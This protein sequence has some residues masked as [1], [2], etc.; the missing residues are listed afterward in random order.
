MSSCMPL[1]GDEDIRVGVIMAQEYGVR[2]HLLGIK[3]A[4][5]NQSNLLLQEADVIHVW[6][7]PDVE[8]FILKSSPLHPASQFKRRI[9]SELLPWK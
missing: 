1:T 6:E 3:P 4:K 7:S 8:T 2:L 9:P 5:S